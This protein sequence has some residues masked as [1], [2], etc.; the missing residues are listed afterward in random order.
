MLMMM[1]PKQSFGPSC[2]G[3]VISSG[4]T[5][6]EKAEIVRVHNEL[7]AKLANGKESR[8]SPGP[9]PAAADMEQMVSTRNI[10]LICMH[11]YEHI[12]RVTN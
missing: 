8:G 7:R 10:I 1:L 11:T 3:S 9:Q 5:D 12:C 4:V 2:K 6:A